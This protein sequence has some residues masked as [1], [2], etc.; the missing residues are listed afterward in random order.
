L[1]WLCVIAAMAAGWL[2][3]ALDAAVRGGVWV[4]AGAQWSGLVLGPYYTAELA[5]TGPT[6]GAGWDLVGSLGGPVALLCL[7][8]GAHVVIEKLRVSGWLRVLMLELAVIGLLWLPTTLAFAVVPGGGGPMAQLYQ[9]LGE[10]QAG[11]W[12]AGGLALLLLWLLA[13]VASRRALATGGRWM[14]TDAP[15]FRRRLVRVVAAYPAAL[16][17]AAQALVAGWAAEVWAAA[18][19]VVTVTVLTARTT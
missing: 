11:R 6:S 7:P 16:A 19:A 15:Q 14:R 8:L 12:A 10:P 18:W 5:G 13:G 2:L 4:L 9:Q 3:H 17:L 1:L